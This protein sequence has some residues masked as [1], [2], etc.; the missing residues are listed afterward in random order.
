MSEFEFARELTRGRD[1]ST[2]VNFSGRPEVKTYYDW[3]NY[4]WR[5][6]VCILLGVRE[7]VPS[8]PW[9]ERPANRGKSSHTPDRE[10]RD[11]S[12]QGQRAESNA[13]SLAQIKRQVTVNPNSIKSRV[14]AYLSRHESA[15]TR[16]IAAALADYEYHSVSVAIHK[17]PLIVL[18]TGKRGRGNSQPGRETRWRLKEGVGDA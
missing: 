1:Y 15:S 2:Q 8:T 3:T 16:E 12:P 4:C 18:V 10:R 17:D 9:S 7:Q 5:T 11:L 6:E 13:R 14:R